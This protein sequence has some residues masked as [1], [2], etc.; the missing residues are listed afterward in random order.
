MTALA[1]ADKAATAMSISVIRIRSPTSPRELIARMPIG[2]S[3]ESRLLKSVT[4]SAFGIFAEIRRRLDRNIGWFLASRRRVWQMVHYH[5]HHLWM[6][7]KTCANLAA[8]WGRP[9][10]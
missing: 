2:D 7:A 5:R 8:E 10:T 4:R 3:V 9:R 6:A 1:Q